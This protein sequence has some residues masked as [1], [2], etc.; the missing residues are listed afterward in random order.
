MIN[1]SV[2][3]SSWELGVKE[4]KSSKGLNAG[5]RKGTPEER[6]QYSRGLMIGARVK[7][8]MFRW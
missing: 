8:R 4:V 2:S 1:N 3:S 7:T 6:K 5:K